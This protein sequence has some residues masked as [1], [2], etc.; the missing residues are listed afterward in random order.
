[1]SLPRIKDRVVYV[2]DNPLVNRLSLKSKW[3]Q[4]RKGE[5]YKKDGELRSV[6][7]KLC[8]QS[9]EILHDKSTELGYF[10]GSR[11]GSST[12]LPKSYVPRA[13]KFKYDKS[14]SFQENLRNEKNS[15]GK[16]QELLNGK[17]YSDREYV[18]DA[19]VDFESSLK[20]HLLFHNKE[21]RVWGWILSIPLWQ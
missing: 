1:M 7:Q 9:A 17:K 21:L 19:I 11:A 10:H 2:Q 16:H 5:I 8:D 12:Y 4:G 3:L 15:I 20:Q 14:V 13:F 6:K 18:N